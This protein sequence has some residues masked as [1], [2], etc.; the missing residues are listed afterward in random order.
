MNAENPMREIRVGKVTLNIGV[1]SPG[2][3]LDNAVKL[4]HLISAVKPVQ[5]KTQKRIP[6]WGLR[7]NL[8]IATKVTV[9]GEDAIKLLK[10]LLAARANKLTESK[11]DAF[12]SLSFGVPEYIDIPG[13]EYQAEIGIIGL[14]V[15]VSLERPGYRVKTR[16][17]KKRLIGHAHKIT[18]EEAISFMK[19]KFDVTLEDKE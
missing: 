4:L 6:G 18:K 16:R 15:A 13:V 9:R 2:E 5:T 8:A 11:F 1:G 12:G 3:K 14:D 17:L 19:E 10:R 7:K